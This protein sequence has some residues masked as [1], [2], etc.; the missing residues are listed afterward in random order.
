M[1]KRL[2][3]F[4]DEPSGRTIAVVGDDGCPRLVAAD[5]AEVLL[6]VP[7]SGKWLR[8]TFLRTPYIA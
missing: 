5:L 7:L 8:E 4:A 2:N 1:H 3:C 6:D